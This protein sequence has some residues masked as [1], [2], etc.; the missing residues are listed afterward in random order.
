MVFCDRREV[1][2]KVKFAIEQATK[3][4]TW[5]RGTALHFL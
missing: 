3:A 2:V 4:R 5:S 1:K